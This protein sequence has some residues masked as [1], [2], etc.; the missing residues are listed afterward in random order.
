VWLAD[1]GSRIE[2]GL[3]AGKSV[4]VIPSA[5]G[6]DLP[7]L[8]SRLSRARVPWRYEAT[9]GT[10]GVTRIAA[11]AP[12]DGLAGLEVRQFYRLT[13][14]GLAPVDTA[15][16]RLDDEQ[17]WLVRGVVGGAVY[18][19][20]ASPLTPAASDVPVSAE[21]VPFVDALVG[22][23]ARRGVED[24]AS[25]EGNEPIRLPARARTLTGPD[26]V[27]VT[28]E[29]GA[30]YRAS[31]AGYYTV[32]DGE[33]DLLAFA[34]N[35][36]L[37]EADLARGNRTELERV[38]PDAEWSWTDATRTDEWQASIFRARRGKLSWRPLVGLLLLVSIV[39]AALAAAGRRQEVKPGSMGE[40]T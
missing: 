32:S 6:L 37:T 8:N 36:P 24:P 18:L 12:L 28:V 11:G 35:A 19:L 21:M 2:E 38:L 7:L 29:G 9:Q 40:S 27:Q 31:Q 5:S 25:V 30:W 23:W 13:P 10:H 14:A 33:R 4:I 22:D 26:A 15:L 39:E 34:V 20:L 17:P 16:I 1:G 3:N